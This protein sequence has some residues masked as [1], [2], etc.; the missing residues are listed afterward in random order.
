MR[1][2]FGDLKIKICDKGKS[3]PCYLE[4]DYHDRF[5]VSAWLILGEEKKVTTVA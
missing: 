4:S 5:Q 2:V 1:F 3:F